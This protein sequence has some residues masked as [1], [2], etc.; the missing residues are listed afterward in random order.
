MDLFHEAMAAA[1]QDSAEIFNRAVDGAKGLPDAFR[2]VA[3]SSAKSPP[4]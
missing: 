4:V 3:A 1:K 2:L